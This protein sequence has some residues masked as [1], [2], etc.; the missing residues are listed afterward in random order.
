MATTILNHPSIGRVVGNTD[1]ERVT[2]YLGLQ[3]A[4]LAD[5]FAPP[6]MKSYTQNDTV[7]AT[8]HG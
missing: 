7:D 4:T 3:Y 6:Q 2:K 5:R 8:K 1:R